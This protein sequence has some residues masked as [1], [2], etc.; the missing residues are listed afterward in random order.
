MHWVSINTQT[1]DP[2]KD[3]YTIALMRCTRIYSLYKSIICA[4]IYL[5][6]GII[7]VLVC[8]L[9]SDSQ[10]GPHTTD[11]P[12]KPRTPHTLWAD[13]ARDVSDVFLSSRNQKTRH[14]YYKLL[15]IIV[16]LKGKHEIVFLTITLYP[17]IWI[18]I[19]FFKIMANFGFF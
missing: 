11:R 7:R 9:T 13:S 3:I 15:F 4:K 2:L 17:R 5:S 16:M 10:D 18:W 14:C 1:P 6:Q 8:R 12:R 19:K